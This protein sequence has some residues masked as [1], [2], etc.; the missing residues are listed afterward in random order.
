VGLKELMLGGAGGVVTVKLL[1]LV[2]VPPG[3]LTW[4]GPLVAPLGTVAVIWVLVFTVKLAAVPLKRTAVAPVKLVPVMVTEVP[5]GPLVGLKELML[6]GA[7]GVVTVKLLAL[8]AVPPGVL[9]WIGPLVAPLGTVAVIWVLVFT[10]KLAAVPLK[11][12]A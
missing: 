1:A 4:I 5:T 9:T 2:A 6:G 10:V 7:G 8:V 12:T 11:R 3:V